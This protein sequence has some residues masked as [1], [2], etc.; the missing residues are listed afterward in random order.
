[1]ESE[2]VFLSVKISLIL[3]FWPK[4]CVSHNTDSLYEGHQSKFI[5]TLLHL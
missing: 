1:L 4:L 5:L 3:N 2:E